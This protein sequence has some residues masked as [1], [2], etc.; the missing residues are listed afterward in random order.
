[1]TT[2]KKVQK[3]HQVVRAALLEVIDRLRDDIAERD[4]TIGNLREQIIAL[5]GEMHE[6]RRRKFGIVSP[7]CHEVIK[8]VALPRPPEQPDCGDVPVNAG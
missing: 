3:K 5:G 7:K 6:T 1:M 2:P 4:H 8:S